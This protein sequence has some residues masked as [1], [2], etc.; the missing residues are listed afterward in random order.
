MEYQCSSCLRWQSSPQEGEPSHLLPFRFK[1]ARFAGNLKFD[2]YFWNL[3]EVE[4]HNT[5][6][7]IKQKSPLVSYSFHH[8]ELTERT[9]FNL[10]VDGREWEQLSGGNL[11]MK[12]IMIF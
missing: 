4:K 11:I 9:S 3:R 8:T 2:V 12:A 5:D 10:L 1:A 7:S 6:N